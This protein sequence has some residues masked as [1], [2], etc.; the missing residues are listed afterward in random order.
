[1]RGC[2]VAPPAHDTTQVGVP[3][4]KAVGELLGPVRQAAAWLADAELDGVAACGHAAL[5]HAVLEGHLPEVR[6]VR[7]AVLGVAAPF[8]RVLHRRL[9]RINT[10]GWLYQI[11]CTGPEHIPL[12]LLVQKQETTGQVVNT[13][14]GV[15]VA[16]LSVLMCD[17]NGLPWSMLHPA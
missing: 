2:P 8:A 13:F 10:K 4:L 17:V 1:M 6:D 9:K 7:G 3:V 15:A 5:V 16:L 12:W 11:K 14:M